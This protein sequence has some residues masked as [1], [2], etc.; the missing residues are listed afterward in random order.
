MDQ[1]LIINFAQQTLGCH[2]PDEVFRDIT[3]SH[4]LPFNIHSRILIGERLLIYLVAQPSPPDEQ[5]LNELATVGLMD[6]DRH[7]Y[8]RLRIVLI[9][10]WANE[11]SKLHEMWNDI[12][13]R[14]EKSH[15]HCLES[16]A[17]LEGG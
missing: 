6:R 3:V 12:V 13:D 7:H 1:A 4:K 2:C 10:A 16:C 11:Q 9:G 17:L 8:N 5:R 14:D 15:L